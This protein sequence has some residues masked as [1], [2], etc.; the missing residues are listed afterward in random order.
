VL[1]RR[2]FIYLNCAQSGFGFCRAP[3]AIGAHSVRTFRRVI[4]GANHAL[5]EWEAGTATAGYPSSIS[6]FLV[7]LAKNAGSKRWWRGLMCSRTRIR[8]TGQV[9]VPQAHG[10]F[11]AGPW[12]CSA[13]GFLRWPHVA[14]GIMQTGREI[15]PIA[16]QISFLCAP[17]TVFPRLDATVLNVTKPALAR[18][19]LI[20]TIGCAE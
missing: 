7:E 8:A 10:S 11:P 5:H 20:R 17:S 3:P 15:A 6:P 16:R 1:S 4:T 18:V 13:G 19:R 2:R 12:R 9:R 14:L